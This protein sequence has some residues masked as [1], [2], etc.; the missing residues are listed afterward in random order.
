MPIRW[1]FGDQHIPTTVVY[2]GRQAMLKYCP[3]ATKSEQG[4]LV[5]LN[6]SVSK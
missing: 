1:I 2:K 6:G 4:E 5:L 3:V